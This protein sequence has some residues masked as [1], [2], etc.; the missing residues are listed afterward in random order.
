M[1][2]GGV[3][4]ASL[5]SEKTRFASSPSGEHD[6]RREQ[7]E[8]R[9]K[10]AS[11]AC[12]SLS[13]L[14]SVR[15]LSGF[16]PGHGCQK[17]TALGGTIADERGGGR[18][19]HSIAQN[20]AKCQAGHDVSKVYDQ[21][22]RGLSTNIVSG[23]TWFVTTKADGHTRRDQGEPPM[24][25]PAGERRRGLGGRC[26]TPSLSWSTRDPLTGS[27]R[28]SIRRG[29]G[30][31]PARSDALNHRATAGKPCSRSRRFARCRN[32]ASTG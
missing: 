5:T 20:M 17:E 29:L 28:S 7:R 15:S 9:T 30:S 14:P 13:S 18:R 16:V 19:L 11:F 3:A 12:P 24:M 27:N 1:R 31:P 4:R 21:S 22:L 2:S 32:S 23:F 25:R 10:T 26:Q 8:R 6:H